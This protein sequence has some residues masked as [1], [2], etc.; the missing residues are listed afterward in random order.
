MNENENEY[1]IVAKCVSPKNFEKRYKALSDLCHNKLDISK[2]DKNAQWLILCWTYHTF[3]NSPYLD[4]LKNILN[5]KYKK[6]INSDGKHIYRYRRTHSPIDTLTKIDA[7]VFANENERH[8]D[9]PACRAMTFYT[10]PQLIAI[11][12]KQG[13]QGPRPKLVKALHETIPSEYAIDIA[14]KC[15]KLYRTSRYIKTTFLVKVIQLALLCNTK[16]QVM[17]AV[18]QTIYNIKHHT[19][20]IFYISSYIIALSNDM[21]NGDADCADIQVKHHSARPEVDKLVRHYEHKYAYTLKRTGVYNQTA[22][23]N[24]IWMQVAP[25]VEQHYSKDHIKRAMDAKFKHSVNV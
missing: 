22:L 21:T 19:D 11:V 23:H 3:P 18:E 24:A 20:V 25:M 14:H 2:D 5:G 4:D 8:R 7:E 10:Y 16:K 1:R 12:K 9:D 17:G 15:N 6:Y 13:K